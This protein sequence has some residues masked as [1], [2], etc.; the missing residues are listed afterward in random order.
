MSVWSCL[1]LGRF[2][3]SWEPTLPGTVWHVHSHTPFL[4]G[5]TTTAFI[6]T[7]LCGVIWLHLML[8]HLFCTKSI[9]IF[10]SIA[11]F[12]WLRFIRNSHTNGGGIETVWVDLD[13][14]IRY[15]NIPGQAYKTFPIIINTK[16]KSLSLQSNEN[17][18]NLKDISLALD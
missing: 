14:I 6:Y 4:T 1:L 12:T 8:S 9:Y 2:Y 17:P 11:G 7:V 16:P 10:F 5:T 18:R 3:G 13:I 15:P